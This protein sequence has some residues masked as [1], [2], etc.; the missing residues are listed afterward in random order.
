MEN[1]RFRADIDDRAG[2]PPKDD[3]GMTKRR[4][5]AAAAFA[6]RLGVQKP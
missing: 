1:P 2:I 5:A 6:C 3:S 4:S